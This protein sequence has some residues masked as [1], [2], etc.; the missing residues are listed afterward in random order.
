M[1]QIKSFEHLSMYPGW[2]LKTKLLKKN[3]GTLRDISQKKLLLSEIMN[4]ERYITL[5]SIRVCVSLMC[6]VILSKHPQ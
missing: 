5:Y 1:Y 2:H 3:K 6:N 4:V